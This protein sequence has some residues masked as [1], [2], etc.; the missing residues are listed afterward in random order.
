MT[1]SWQLMMAGA[2]AVAVIFLFQLEGNNGQRAGSMSGPDLLAR[3]PSMVGSLNGRPISRKE[4]AA[5]LEGTPNPTRNEIRAAVRRLIDA[6]LL[7]EATAL[8]NG[9]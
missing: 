7:A 3:L 1:R 9:G 6:R 5:E 8:M 2:S 4:V